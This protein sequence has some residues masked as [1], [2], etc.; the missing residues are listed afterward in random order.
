MA[1]AR[2]ASTQNSRATASAK[3]A[4]TNGAA[5]KQ[6]AAKSTVKSATSSK[7]VPLLGKI[8]TQKKPTLGAYKKPPTAKV[9]AANRNK[10]EGDAAKPNE[11][12]SKAD[13]LIPAK[14]QLTKAKSPSAS[15][16]DDI[17]AK[18]K[19]ATEKVAKTSSDAKRVGAK[20]Q[21]KSADA[22]SPKTKK[23]T[24]SPAKSPINTR[25]KV[26]TSSPGEGTE[27]AR[28]ANDA[29]QPPT[30]AKSV[31]AVPQKLGLDEPEDRDATEHLK[32]RPSPEGQDHVEQEE[33]VESALE[34]VPE[35]PKSVKDQE[36]E[37]STNSASDLFPS[38]DYLTVSQKTSD[39]YVEASMI[40]NVDLTVDD[41]PEK[42]KAET[43]SLEGGSEA[44][45]QAATEDMKTISK[46]D[47]VALLP[48]AESGQRDDDMEDGTFIVPEL[49]KKSAENEQ[50]T[51]RE[52][53]PSPCP[54]PDLSNDNEAVSLSNFRDLNVDEIRLE[55]LP[56]DVHEN[57]TNSPPEEINV[58][59]IVHDDEAQGPCDNE[60]TEK[61][62]FEAEPVQGFRD[63][64]IDLI[65]QDAPVARE[66]IF[67]QPQMEESTEAVQTAQNRSN[68]VK[69][70]D[71]HRNEQR[72]HEL[73]NLS[74]VGLEESS[75][76]SDQSNMA[77]AL[78][79]A[80]Q[81][82]FYWLGSH[83]VLFCRS[84]QSTI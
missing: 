23:A 25:T 41:N 18:S 32:T 6:T 7:P 35:S 40:A 78:S 1:A 28:N 12:R 36:K 48:L 74:R 56:S 33:F 10:R 77:T 30:P 47:A 63:N 27:T 20:P 14:A 82:K 84:Y 13:K 5:S 67:G 62:S 21:T 39:D 43:A 75:K 66:E 34:E 79:D 76:N 59:V 73:E 53:E 69:A 51:R 68:D 83:H 4:A 65:K 72:D 22:V 71:D 11:K 80:S 60:T 19:S 54:A 49:E 37:E 31:N 17:K 16:K 46:E 81:S 44:A 52:D 58:D 8:S 55:E 57:A 3:T 45:K 70:V 2:P 24:S 15:I 42:E 29:L 26:V 9:D 38:S 61:R 64:E 50:E